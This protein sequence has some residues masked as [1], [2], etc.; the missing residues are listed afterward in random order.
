MFVGFLEWIR[1]TDGNYLLC[2]KVSRVVRNIVDHVLELPISSPRVPTPQQPEVREPQQQHSG[3]DINIGMMHELTTH[4]FV[5]EERGSY[6]PELMWM[7]SDDTD[8]CMD[9]LNNVD[10]TQKHWF[11][12]SQ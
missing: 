5:G 10:W 12:L 4:G 7:A 3:Q 1:P 6:Q 11:D 8:D 2:S 9:W